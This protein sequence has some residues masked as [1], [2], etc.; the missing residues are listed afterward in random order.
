MLS[1]HSD[2]QESWGAVSSCG[3]PTL[4]GSEAAIC[5][6]VD[7]SSCQEL[8]E[9]PSQKPSRTRVNGTLRS[10][11]LSSANTLGE[12]RRGPETPG[13]TP[14]SADT[15]CTFG[16][17]RRGPP[18]AGSSL[19]ALRGCYICMV[20]D[21]PFCRKLTHNRIGY[22]CCRSVR[23]NSAASLAWPGLSPLSTNFPEFP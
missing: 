9:S 10:E 1:A 21:C 14:S 22:A 18:T 23:S 8:G 5:V 20:G 11:Q 4:G 3:A 13:R 19:P 12:L 17:L 15:D 16:R 7:D 6:G 2:G